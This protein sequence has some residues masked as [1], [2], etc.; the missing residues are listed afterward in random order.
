L[1]SYRFVERVLRE[2][3]PEEIR[4]PRLLTGDDLQEMG[5]QPG[6]LFG[7]IL[8]AVEDAQLE[9]QLGSHKDATEYVRAKF[10][11]GQAKT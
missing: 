3:P 2:T 10:G 6:P 5:Y 8:R 1:E 7:Q 4:P 11:G 9:G